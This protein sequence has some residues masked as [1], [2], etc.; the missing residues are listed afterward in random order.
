M[1][2]RTESELSQSESFRVM[3]TRHEVHPAHDCPLGLHRVSTCITRQ[4]HLLFGLLGPARRRYHA[5]PHQ[6]RAP[7]REL[8]LRRECELRLE[9]QYHRVRMEPPDFD[10]S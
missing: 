1:A 4:L 2:I 5:D 6:S 10:R 9:F 7:Q 3:A 8:Q